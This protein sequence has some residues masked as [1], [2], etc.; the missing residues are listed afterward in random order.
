ML[1]KQKSGYG[2]M[3]WKNGSKAGSVYRGE[4]RDGVMQGKGHLVCA[5]GDVFEGQFEKDQYHGEGT[6]TSGDKTN[7]TGEWKDG[8]KHGSGVLTTSKEKYV[9]QFSE[10]QKHGSKGSINTLTYKDGN[11]YSGDFHFDQI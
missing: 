11:K 4:W 5:N 10:D 6:L 9:G 2:K 3:Q 1:Q 8:L 7:Y